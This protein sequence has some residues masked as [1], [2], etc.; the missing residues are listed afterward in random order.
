MRNWIRRGLDDVRDDVLS[1]QVASTRRQSVEPA[2]LGLPV[3][4]QVLMSL[5]EEKS[6]SHRLH[7]HTG[8]PQ[9]TISDW[10]LKMRSRD[11][12][13]D[14]MPA[15]ARECLQAQRFAWDAWRRDALEAWEAEHQR[16]FVMCGQRAQP[17][18]ASSL[19]H[20]SRG[21][22]TCNW[23][24]TASWGFCPTCG[25]KSLRQGL[26]EAKTHWQ[27]A[28]QCQ[29][30]CDRRAGTFAEEAA[31]D[32]EQ[33]QRSK[34]RSKAY[35]TPQSADFPQEIATLSFEDAKTLA[36]VDLHV[37]WETVRPG[38]APVAS[39][40]KRSVMGA[41][42]RRQ[43]VASQVTE[44]AKPALE[45]LLRHN[46]TYKAL[47]T[48]HEFLLG[49]PDPQPGELPWWRIRTAELL[50]HRPGIE[51]AAR[52][53]LYPW[54]AMADTDLS[55]RL[56]PDGL[57][58]ENANPSLKTSFQRKVHSRCLTYQ[59]DYPLMML[60]HDISLARKLT[61][62]AAIAEQRKI[63]PDEAA[64]G[65][66]LFSSF[67]EHETQKLEDMCRQHQRMPTCFFTVAPSE[68]TF[69][70]HEGIFAWA[71]Q[72]VQ[73]LSQMQSL[74]TMHLY[75]ALYLGVEGQLCGQGLVGCVRSGGDPRVHLALRIPDA[76]Y[77][78]HSRAPVGQVQG[79]GHSLEAVWADEA[80]P[81]FSLCHLAGRHV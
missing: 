67:W 78:A 31:E 28:Q 11:M 10:H 33:P 13:A 32:V 49:Q 24:V 51:V 21:S 43:S 15:F 25:R 36:L 48:E 75:N 59:L 39:R 63:A 23:I 37:T 19:D 58:A 27:V 50:L 64:K 46:S 18:I 45:W 76:R 61:S 38:K 4:E 5:L 34:Q 22:L 53:W 6:N 3:I 80:G 71:K 16:Q 17:P 29:G 2:Q 55:M 65:S 74:L 72:D 40:R 47:H 7:R 79:E 14:D 44:L 52:P 35:V 69:P 56:K 8:I 81:Q 60:M 77:S 12:S 62:I 26:G 66:Q 1:Y 42:W 41:T 30:G 70:L 68:W 54:P 20:R 9:K 73:R 57:V